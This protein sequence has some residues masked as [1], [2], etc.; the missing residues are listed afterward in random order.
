MEWLDALPWGQLLLLG[1][2]LALAPFTPEPH[3]V[4]KIRMLSQGDLNKPM[5]IFDLLMHSTPLAIIAIK[6]LRQFVLKV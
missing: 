4:E 5:D 2:L 1:G 3:L 6:A